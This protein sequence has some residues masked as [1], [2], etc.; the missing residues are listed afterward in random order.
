MEMSGCVIVFSL[1]VWNVCKD[2]RN[3]NK[4]ACLFMKSIFPFLI[5]YVWLSLFFKKDKMI[6][7]VQGV[8]YSL[9]FTSCFVLCD[10]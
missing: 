8:F 2:G 6:H 3:L 7:F 4:M 5:L 9:I 10:D 1:W